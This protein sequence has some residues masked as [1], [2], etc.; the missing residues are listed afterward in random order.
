[1]KDEKIIGLTIAEKIQVLE[2]AVDYAKTATTAS[3]VSVY[4]DLIAIISK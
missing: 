1:M 2:L 4:Q 3:P